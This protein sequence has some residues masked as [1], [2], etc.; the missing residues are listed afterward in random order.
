MNEWSVL[1]LDSLLKSS[2]ILNQFLRFT[3]VTLHHKRNCAG[4][5][6]QSEWRL[7]NSEHSGKLNSEKVSSNEC[8]FKRNT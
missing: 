1:S 7:V 2:H 6:A 4:F 5:G 3:Y 8:S